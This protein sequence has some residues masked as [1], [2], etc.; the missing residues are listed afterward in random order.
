MTLGLEPMPRKPIK[1][2]RIKQISAADHKNHR[3]LD[4]EWHKNKVQYSLQQNLILN[5]ASIKSE[6][7]TKDPWRNQ[8]TM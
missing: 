1:D 7:H 4:F 8:K 2:I 5:L 6:I 3:N